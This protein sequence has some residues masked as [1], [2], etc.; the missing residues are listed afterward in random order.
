MNTGA[1]VAVEKVLPP[2]STDCA[3]HLMGNWS[4]IRA[5]SLLLCESPNKT[6]LCVAMSSS[7]TC[8]SSF[9]R[10][11]PRNCARQSFVAFASCEE[12][13]APT[14]SLRAWPVGRTTRKLSMKASSTGPWRPWRFTSMAGRGESLA[15][16]NQRPCASFATVT[17]HS[18]LE[19]SGV[20]VRRSPLRIKLRTDLEPGARATRSS[21]TFVVLISNRSPVSRSATSARRQCCSSATIS[22]LPA[23]G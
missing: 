23:P 2:T 22:T 8:E 5:S 18:S 21:A 13:H 11:S 15:A 9:T 14:A 12:L 6:K 1:C 10:A 20:A 16:S 19:I 3:F 4:A 17:L 7:V